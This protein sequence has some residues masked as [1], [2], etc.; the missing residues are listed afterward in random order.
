MFRKNPLIQ[1]LLSDLGALQRVR[2][3]K[4]LFI[5]LRNW[6]NPTIFEW[7]KGFLSLEISSIELRRL[8]CI[9]DVAKA[10]K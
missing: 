2:L 3:M 10:I 4:A 5:S 9:L 8:R 6:N 1:N 7:K